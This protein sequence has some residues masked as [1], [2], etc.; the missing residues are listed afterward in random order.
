ME[1]F[2]EHLQN[3]TDARSIISKGGFF[4]LLIVVFAETGLFFGFFLPGDYLLVLAGLLCATG[5]L[6]MHIS[7]LVLSLIAA[8]VLGNY[9]GY[10]FGYRTGPVLF[11]RNE[12]L[13]FKKR[14]V[15]MA[16][17][18]YAKYGGMALVLGRFFPIIRTFAP[19]FAGVVKLDVKKFTLYNFIGSIMWVCT[20]TLTG[21]FLGRRY[22]EEIKYYLKYVVLGLILITTAPLIFAYIRRKFVN[23]EAGNEDT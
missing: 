13:F 14:Y 20:L 16:E 8:G 22:P 4:L 2:W 11:K 21:F 3:L 7:V 19:I 17:E 9:T 10:W 15:T 18:F 5:V 1:Q 12:S 6:D 23:T